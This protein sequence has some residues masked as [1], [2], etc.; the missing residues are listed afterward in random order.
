MPLSLDYVLTWPHSLAPGSTLST[1]MWDDNGFFL[2]RSF[3]FCGFRFIQP[4]FFSQSVKYWLLSG[5]GQVW[6]FFLPHTCGSVPQRP[7]SRLPDWLDSGDSFWLQFAYWNNQFDH[8][9]N[10]ISC[11]LLEFSKVDMRAHV[12]WIPR[13]VFFFLLMGLYKI[14]CTPHQQIGGEFFIVKRKSMVTTCSH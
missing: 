12:F 9:S 4:V 11:L 8:R 13:K 3:S 1:A 6:L 5:H 10:P 14:I 2:W 7:T